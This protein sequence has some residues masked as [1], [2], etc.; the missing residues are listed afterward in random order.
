MQRTLFSCFKYVLSRTHSK[1]DFIIYANHLAV[2]YSSYSCR[3][4]IRLISL[5]ASKNTYISPLFNETSYKGSSKILSR[6]QVSAYSQK[7]FHY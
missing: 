1:T 2:L 5:N 4:E 6:K 7:H 3:P